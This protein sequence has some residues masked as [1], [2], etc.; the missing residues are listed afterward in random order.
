[1]PTV[2]VAAVVAEA[3]N[4]R[5]A[6]LPALGASYSFRR[7]YRSQTFR[8]QARF[9]ALEIVADHY[10][11]ARGERARELALLAEHFRLIPHALELSLG[12][13]DGIDADYLRALAGLIASVRAPW[14]SEHIAFTRAGGIR[15]G[16]L[17][18]L[19]FTHEA[20]DVV[21]RNVTRV[22]ETIGTPLLLENIACALAFPGAQMREEDFLC[23]LVERTGCG[24]LLDVANLHANALNL[25]YDPLE[26]IASLPPESV[27]QVHVAGGEWIGKEYVDGHARS[28]PEA[29]WE[30]AERVCKRFAVKAI[31]VER[32]ENLPH[33]E[34]LLAEVERAHAIG[35]RYG[36]WP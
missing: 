32:D 23:A 13:A 8:E 15:I 4:A 26:F 28:V 11:Y 25:G 27:V 12:S 35:A 7:P 36:R 16:H 30:L 17:A 24:L 10:L 6:A 1:M 14:W 29:V 18:P 21:A 3:E 20:L 5:L 31:V 34:E 9:G 2:V 22:R 19:P 33:F